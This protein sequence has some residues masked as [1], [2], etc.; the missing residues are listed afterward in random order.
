MRPERAEGDME[1][2]LTTLRAGSDPAAPV[3][4]GA[5]SVTGTR[6]SG[7]DAAAHPA[8]APAPGEGATTAVSTAA[9]VAPKTVA[10]TAGAL[11]TPFRCADA[12]CVARRRSG[13]I[14]V[15]AANQ[16]AAAQACG[17]ARL[18]VIDD[19]TVI[20]PCNDPAIAVITKRMLALRGSAAVTFTGAGPPRVTYAI[21]ENPRVWHQQRRF[22][23]EARR[24]PPYRRESDEE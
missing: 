4:A 1:L 21:G 18:I 17:I 11:E 6:E 20:D 3:A 10:P 9:S 12:L 19:A 14:I 8:A 2:V 24:L 15:H 22:S 23:R 16:A 13:A 7:A 5:L